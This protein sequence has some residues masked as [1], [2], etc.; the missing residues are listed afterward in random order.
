MGW[1]VINHS[2][3]QSWS[4]LSFFS[5]ESSLPIDWCPGYFWWSSQIDNEIDSN[6][7]QWVFS[8]EFDPFSQNRKLRTYHL[9]AFMK[10]LDD[11]ISV[12]VDTLLH[13]LQVNLIRGWSLDVLLCHRQLRIQLKQHAMSLGILLNQLEKVVIAFHVTPYLYRFR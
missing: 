12:A 4:N 10:V 13:D 3:C 2:S 1:G 5:S 11:A 9:S 6:F 7:N 8:Q